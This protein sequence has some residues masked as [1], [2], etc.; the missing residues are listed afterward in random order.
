MRKVKMEKDELLQNLKSNHQLLISVSKKIQDKGLDNEIID[1]KWVLKDVL[2]HLSLYER[3]AVNVLKMKSMENNSFY[4]RTD[5]DRNEEN[6]TK[7]HDKSLQ[8]ILESSNEIFNDLYTLTSKLNQQEL[9]GS[10][11]GMKKTVGEFIAG[12]SY[13]HYP[14]HIP[15]L[16]K[17]FNV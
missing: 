10:F 1:K 2:S 12:E 16:Q 7:T 11:S 5:D 4:S 6:F 3:E 15:K 8:D 17:R 13:R 9:D 14:D